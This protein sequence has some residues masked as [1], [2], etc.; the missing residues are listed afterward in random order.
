M[1][2]LTVRL[3]PTINTY[4][5]KMSEDTGIPKSSLILFAVHHICFHNMSLSLPKGVPEPSIR[6]SLRMPDH[7]KEDVLAHANA[8]NMSV[9]AFINAC[10]HFAI[11]VWWEK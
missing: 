6:F 11:V 1:A 5:E 9:N 10:V 7:V 4:L 8:R 2:I 3:L